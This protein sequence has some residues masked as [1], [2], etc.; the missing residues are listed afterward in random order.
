VKISTGSSTPLT[1]CGGNARN[2]DDARKESRVDLLMRRLVFKALFNA[3]IRDATFTVLPMLGVQTLKCHLNR[4]RRR[5]RLVRVIAILAADAEKGH[6]S[7]AEK[8]IGH[9]AVLALDEAGKSGLSEKQQPANPSFMM[10]LAIELNRA[11]MSI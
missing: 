4:T 1:D 5:Q 2:S 9:S 8:F 3:S 6:E 10:R 11:Q 7:V